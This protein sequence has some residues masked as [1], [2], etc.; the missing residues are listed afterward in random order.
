V[1]NSLRVSQ[2]NAFKIA[3]FWRFRGKKVKTFQNYPTMCCTVPVDVQFVDAPENQYPIAG[4]NYKIRCHV[5]GEPYPLIDWYKGDTLI[6]ENS[7]N[8]IRQADGLFIK[9]VTEADDGTYKCAAVVMQT[10]VYKSRN[11]KVEVQVPPQILP[12]EPVEVVEGETASTKCA[13]TGKPPPVYQWIK[14]D[15]RNDLSST[16]RF[17]VKNRT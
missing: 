17:N 15:Q 16:D 1:L 11:I 4:K 3:L 9:N 10:G 14:L 8:Y 13:A 7:E 12:L 2:F 6:A 5:K